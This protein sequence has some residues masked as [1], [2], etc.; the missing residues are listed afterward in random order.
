MKMLFS[1]AGICPEKKGHFQS[2][3]TK[4]VS[5]LFA[6]SPKPTKILLSKLLMPWEQLPACIPARQN[7]KTELNKLR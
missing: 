5:P 2:L 3:K 1:I 6:L 4:K 7:Q